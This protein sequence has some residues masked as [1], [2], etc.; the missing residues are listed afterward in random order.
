MEMNFIFGTLRAEDKSEL[1][2]Q[3]ARYMG[4]RRMQYIRLYN[5]HRISMYDGA[6]KS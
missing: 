6:L 1:T 3:S 2:N 4:W 5:I